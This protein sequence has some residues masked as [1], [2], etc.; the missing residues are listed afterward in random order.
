M[1]D[2][3]V[4]TSGRY[5]CEAGL[6][7]LYNLLKDQP[8][9]NFLVSLALVFIAVFTLVFLMAPVVNLWRWTAEELAHGGQQQ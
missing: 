4:D 1:R 2:F 7:L 6:V 8:K 5:L 9:I 3:E